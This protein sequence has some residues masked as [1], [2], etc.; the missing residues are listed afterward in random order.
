MSAEIARQINQQPE[1]QQGPS[2]NVSV[3]L[4]DKPQS[5]IDPKPAVPLQTIDLNS[6]ELQEILKEGATTLSS[7][8]TS[9]LMSFSSSRET[10]QNFH[11]H[12]AVVFYNNTM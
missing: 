3:D 11:F 2:T 8:T 6:A 7:S 12:G 10:V 4:E 5:T 9:N 1:V